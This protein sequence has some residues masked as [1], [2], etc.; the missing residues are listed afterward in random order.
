MLNSY[1]D[2]TKDIVDYLDGD[3]LNTV[4]PDCPGTSNSIQKV[5][6]KGG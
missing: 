5:S 6:K 1:T 3:C 2:I 4:H